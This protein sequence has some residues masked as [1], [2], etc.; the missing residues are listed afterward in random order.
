MND[1]RIRRCVTEECYTAT[2]SCGWSTC[3]KTRDLRDQDEH[4]HLTRVAAERPEP[5]R[6]RD[7]G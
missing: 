3:R 7:A 1:H 2:C 5:W 4:G 6:I